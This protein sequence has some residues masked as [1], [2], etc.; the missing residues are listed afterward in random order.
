MDTE[1]N[2][3]SQRR[4][5]LW[6]WL[7]GYFTTYEKIWM[8]SMVVLT[9]ALAILFP[10]DDTNG[11]SGLV[12]TILYVFDVLIGLLCEL[13]F[14]KQNKWGFLIYNIVEVI[15]IVT[16]IILRTRFASMA[17]AMFY[18]IPAHT[19]GFF[20]WRRFQDKK[21]SKKTVV[22]KLKAWQTVLIFALTIIWTLVIG[23]LVAK[24]S[25]ETEFYS[26]DTV[27]KVIAY[28]D[29]C[30]SIM[31]IIDGILMFFRSNESWWTWYLY[32]A[33]ETA[34]NII[35]GQW[36]L[37]VYKLG[38]LTNTTYG[39]IKWTKYIKEN[40]ASDAT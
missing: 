30:L 21:D 13:L 6:E 8:L 24:Y 25:P 2:I 28:M 7:K 10:E 15:E 40:E 36:I 4:K 20:Q 35:S 16:M 22:R 14:S 5:N 23:Y 11:V 9:V 34:I 33:V 37:L 1:L 27:V 39:I 19:L 31:S 17:V 12:I 26:S 3:E 32:I 29:A 38:Y 18:W